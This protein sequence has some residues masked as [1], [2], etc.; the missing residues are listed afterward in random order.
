MAR[1]EKEGGGKLQKMNINV[2]VI[3]IL[4]WLFNGLMLFLTF[5]SPGS[6]PMRFLRLLFLWPIFIISKTL[7]V[8]NCHMDSVTP[9]RKIIQ[10]TEDFFFHMKGYNVE[11]PEEAIKK[12]PDF[13]KKNWP[14]YY[15]K[16]QNK[17]NNHKR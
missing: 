2:M 14:K 12:Y 16:Y 17:I 5:I 13:Y 4:F 9:Y 7:N 6:V 1:G 8:N 10:K 3:I 15:K 11:W